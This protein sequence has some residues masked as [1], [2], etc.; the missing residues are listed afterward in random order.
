MPYNLGMDQITIVLPFALPPPEL[1]PDLL[2]EMKVPALAALLSRT[3]SLHRSTF[4]GGSRNLPH[5]A[6]LAAELGLGSPLQPGPQDDTPATAPLA[7]AAMRGFGLDAAEG[8]WFFVHPVHVQIARNH[9]LMG[10]PRQLPIDEAGSRTLFEAAKPYFDEVGKPLLYG[11]AQTW[12]VRADDWAG[13]RTASPD[14]AAGQNLSGWMPEGDGALATRKLQ[15]EVQ[16]LWHE[17]PANEARQ[18][19]G[20][21]PVNAYWLWGGASGTAPARD[22]AAT[23]YAGDCPSWLAG[24]AAPERRQPEFAAIAA[25]SGNGVVVLGSLMA[26]AIA[27][28]WAIWLEQIQRLEQQWFAPALDALKSGAVGGVT[29]VLGNRDALLQAASSRNAQRK[30]WRSINLNHLLT[31]TPTGAA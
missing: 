26:A 6:W 11:D 13:L 31:D 18:A 16:M 7:A 21:P 8:H 10:D 29:L 4:D 14:A 20:L 15:N 23:F 3:G 19:R 22:G 5:E 30:F 25:G 17:H 27:S 28:D 1:A 24:L 12:F 2:R 9:L